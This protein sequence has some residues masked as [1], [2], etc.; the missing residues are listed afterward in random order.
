LKTVSGLAWVSAGMK[1]VL[2]PLLFTCGAYLFGFRGGDFIIMF[3]LFASPT[4]ILSFIM[5]DTMGANAKLAGTI[6]LISTVFSVFTISL[7]LMIL[8]QFSLL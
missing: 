7:G 8:K 1:I 4:A 2:V 6:I 3:I 5:A